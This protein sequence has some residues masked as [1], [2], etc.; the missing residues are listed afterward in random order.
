[1]ALEPSKLGWLA[2]VLGVVAVAATGCETQAFCFACEETTPTTTTTTGLGG[3]GGETCVFDCPG[4]NGQGG[5][6][7]NG[8]CVPSNSGVE[9]CDGFDNDCNDAVDDLTAEELA[10]PKTCGT[11]QNDCYANAANCKVD[12]VGC[13]PSVDPGMLPGTCTCAECATD[14]FDLDGDATCEYFCK[15]TADDDALCNNKDDDCDG[16]KDEDVDLC[17]DPLNCG[18]CGRSCAVLHGQGDCVKMGAGATCTEA[19]TACEIASCDCNG[20]D[21][22]WFDLDGSVATGC[23]YQCQITN[24]GAEICDG[25]DND[26]DGMIDGSDDLSADMEVGAE[27]FGDPDGLCADAANAGVTECQGGLIVCV[28]MNVLKENQT[29]ETCNGVDDDCDSVV[30]DSP[31]DVGASCGVSAIFPC[32]LGTQQCVGG[33]LACVGAVAPG[34]ESCNGVDDDCDGN[35]DK[36]GNMAPADSVGACNVPLAPPAGA[37]SPCQAG[38]K[39]CQG[40]QVVCLGSVGPTSQNDSCGDDSNCDGVLTGQP[41]FMSNVSFCGDCATNCQTGALHTIVACVNG[42]CQNQGCEPGYYDLDGNGSCEYACTFVSAQEACNGVD[43]DCDGQIDEGVVTPLPTQ[44]CGVSPSA[45]SSECQP[46]A[47]G[48]QVACMNGAWV[49]TFPAGVCPGGCSASDEICDTLDND[50]DG[51][52][53]ENVGNFGLACASDD[54]LPPPGHG[55]CRTTGTFQCNG[56][57]A[58]ACTAMKADCAGLPGG[59]TELC[60][61]VDNDCDGLVDETFNA[62]GT[63]AANYVKPAVTRLATNLWTYTYEASRPS[64]TDQAPGTGNGFWTTAPAGQTLDKTPACSAPGKIPWFNVTPQEVQQ[65]CTQMGGSICTRTQFQTACTPNTPTTSCVYGYNPRGASGSACATGFTGT[66]FCNL[67]QAFDFDPDPMVPGDQ[68]GLL[69]TASPILQNCWADWSGLQGN[70]AATNKL[71]DLTGNLREITSD[72]NPAPCGGA[73]QPPCSVFRLMGGAFNSE[74]ESGAA[75]GFTFYTVNQTFKFFDT[76]FRCCFTQNPSP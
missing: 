7:G 21:D 72:T 14:Y 73:N 9:I 26:C 59:C 69:P 68:D 13:D 64:S 53:N 67:A 38:Q 34:V 28:G 65:V 39:A 66:K 76:G 50:C 54:G 18:K 30:D 57:N 56:P 37:T 15:K 36:I 45:V 40:G 49:C 27:C 6:G 32:S 51:I 23:E 24:G 12:A 29:L 8:D 11:C 44:V 63:N 16:V 19:N 60:D 10:D 55:A 46:G 20:P 75:C 2:G 17:D 22:C 48:V 42:V 33:Q 5:N 41:D 70:S 1:M 52:L 71:Y 31:T 74:A 4:G 25:L 47:G 62:P 61:G 3:A 35:I 58:T 43:D